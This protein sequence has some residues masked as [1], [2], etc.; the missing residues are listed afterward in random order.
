MAG[1][2]CRVIDSCSTKSIRTG[3][4]VDLM[5][6]DPCWFY[7][8]EDPVLICT[9]PSVRWTIYWRRDD[10]FIGLGGRPVGN[11]IS[12]YNIT[13][14]MSFNGNST[15]RQEKLRVSRIMAN[16]SLQ[17]KS[18]FRCEHQ[19]YSSPNVYLKISGK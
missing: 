18:K 9:V 3:N 11:D 13:T 4:R 7:T 12:Q 19:G 16:S 10:M 6:E 14:Y 5:T 8:N 17:M 15:T 1:N 2:V